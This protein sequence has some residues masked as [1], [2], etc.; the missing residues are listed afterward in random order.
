M[1]WLLH[2]IAHIYLRVITCQTLVKQF[3]TLCIQS[4]FCLACIITVL[5]CFSYRCTTLFY[6]YRSNC[7][8]VT[9]TIL[10]FVY[11]HYSIDYITIAW[12]A[13]WK[14]LANARKYINISR[15]KTIE[16]R[17][18]AIK[19]WSVEFCNFFWLEK[20]NCVG[21]HVLLLFPWN[22]E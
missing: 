11:S 18:S 21:F 5:F 3:Y 7:L 12:I 8:T 10:F 20:K 2:C 9:G 19:L 22:F 16:V 17:S 15:A 1:C 13:S 4:L 14:I 6:I